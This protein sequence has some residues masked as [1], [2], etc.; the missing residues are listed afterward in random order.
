MSGWL[1][2]VEGE[3]HQQ[4][5]KARIKIDLK[6]WMEHIHTHIIRTHTLRAYWRGGRGSAVLIAK[7][8]FSIA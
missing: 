6:E 5:V 7:R 1:A 2:D 4:G 8:A 3:T